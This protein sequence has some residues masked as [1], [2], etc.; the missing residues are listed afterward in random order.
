MMTDDAQ[1]FLAKAVES[2]AGA[3]SEFT[4]G[5]YNNCANRCYYACFQA[6]VAALS[7]AGI[8]S[9]DGRW[10]HD[11]VQSQ[12]NGQLVY[13]RKRYPPPL[14]NILNENMG[15]RHFADYRAVSV[16]DPQIRRALRRA[17]R[18]VNAVLEREGAPL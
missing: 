18:F 3:E 11:F 16:S 10:P 13:R 12:F 2:L 5:R 15:L 4:A 1:V 9:A 17:R 7:V 14:A 8:Q 6:A